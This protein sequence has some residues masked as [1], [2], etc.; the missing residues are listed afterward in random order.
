MA[1]ITILGYSE[2]VIYVKHNLINIPIKARTKPHHNMKI[3]GPY[4][5][6][7]NLQKQQNLFGSVTHQDEII[8]E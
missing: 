2:N 7:C 3:V 6:Q 4:K 8:S 1:C 5:R